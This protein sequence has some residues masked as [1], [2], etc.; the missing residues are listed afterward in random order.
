M[1]IL[2]EGARKAA[3]MISESE[4]YRSRDQGVLTVPANTTFAAGTVLGR[5]TSGQKFVRHDVDG[6]DDG[7]RVAAGI[8]FDN[9][10]NATDSAVDYPATVLMRASQVT[11]SDIVYE[12][13]ADA[14][15]KLASN[16]VLATLG[17]IV[18]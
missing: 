6:T 15:A 5:V 11:G 10:V 16:V 12:D 18:R 3:F 1:T 14:A 8:L 9:F 2:T 7:R 17:I 4:D 13:G